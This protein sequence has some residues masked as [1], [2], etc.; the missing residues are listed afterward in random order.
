MT[1][2][3]IC[4][5]KYTSCT[6]Q[7]LECPKCNESFCKECLK[8]DI[9]TDKE[10]NRIKCFF[11]GEEFTMDFLKGLFPSTF[12]KKVIMPKREID[13]FVQQQMAQLPATQVYANHLT[14]TENWKKEIKC[15]IEEKIRQLREEI[16]KSHRLINDSKPV[17]SGE[18][19]EVFKFK[20][21]SLACTGFV[22]STGQ[23]MICRKD[24]CL[25]CMEEKEEGHVCDKEV[26]ESI[27]LLRKDCKPCPHC[28]LFA[29]KTVGCNQM[30]C[31]DCKGFWDWGTGKPVII[32]LAH[33]AHNPEYLEWER[34]VRGGNIRADERAC[35]VVPHYNEYKKIYSI[36]LPMFKGF[37]D[38]CLIYGHV[39]TLEDIYQKCTIDNTHKYRT[40]RA[41]YLNKIITEKDFKKK[42][43]QMKLIEIKNR[44]LSQ[45]IF[46]F[47]KA[48][49]IIL[50]NMLDITER[51]D[52]TKTKILA[53]RTVQAGTPVISYCYEEILP[54]LP[55]LK[56]D[57]KDMIEQLSLNKKIDDYYI[58]EIKKFNKEFGYRTYED[59]ETMYSR[60]MYWDR[61]G[62]RQPPYSRIKSFRE[63]E[64]LATKDIWRVFDLAVAACKNL[65][66]GR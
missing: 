5:S 31:P 18:S 27:T 26:L 32:T 64:K 41:N 16:Y 17:Y 25:D 48:K 7:K 30:W 14:E 3:T 42:V 36:N 47:K 50:R 2:C 53:L 11:C 24:Y 13:N 51:T 65:Q 58:G 40:L 44:H 10:D 59:L 66:T 22:S 39:F 8:N 29:Q 19:S 43:K 49:L 23:C 1:E 4:T 15:P 60:Y 54:D 55:I 38:A 61:D 37:D 52:I 62:I 34:R 63:N 6:R 28:G 57:Y 33:H 46:G 45:I 9:N 56:K 12:L 20:C 21:P 35:D